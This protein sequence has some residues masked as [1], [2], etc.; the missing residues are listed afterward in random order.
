VSSVL[1][2]AHRSLSK[3]KRNRKYPNPNNTI[4]VVK[5]IAIVC[6]R[7]SVCEP[8]ALWCTCIKE[9][10]S[11]ARRGVAR[12]DCML[13]SVC[14]VGIV[15]SCSCWDL[16]GEII[17]TLSGRK[18]WG[19]SRSVCIDLRSVGYTC[20]SSVDTWQADALINSPAFTSTCVWGGLALFHGQ[21]TVSC[22]GVGK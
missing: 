12:R 6:Q 10:M 1:V 8:C 15:I 3:C 7:I 18:I 21:R 17:G 20:K 19:V 11:I 14:N 9:S 22:R 4:L 16:C 5:V 2:A 13:S